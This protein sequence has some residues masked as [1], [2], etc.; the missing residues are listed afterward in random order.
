MRGRAHKPRQRGA[1][2]AATA[3]LLAALVL[4]FFPA[5]SMAQSSDGLLNLDV[6]AQAGQVLLHFT[7]LP[8]DFLY[9]PALRSG[10]GSND[11]ELDRGQFDRTRWVRF[12]RVGNRVLLIEPNLA[13]RAGGGGSAEHRAVEESFTQSVLAGF[14]I[15]EGDADITVDIAPFL[16]SDVRRIGS[17]IAELD[18]GSFELD[19]DRS[20]IEFDG[21]RNFPSNSLLPVTMTFSGSEPGAFIRSVTPTA[22]SLTVRVVHQFIRLPD[23]GYAPRRFHPRS[24]Y[25]PLAY[26]DYGAPLNEDVER[27][28]IYRHRLQP[29]QILHYYV[30][31]GAP[32]PV[33]SALLEGASWWSEAFAAAGFPG[34]FSVDVLPENADPLD[35]RYNVIQWVHRSTRGWS[36]G[37]SVADPRNGEIIKGHVSLGSL[38]VRQDQLIAEALTAPFTSAD[39]RSDAAQEMALARLRQLAAHE[40]GHTLGLDHNFAASFSGDA[41]VMDYPHPELYLGENGDIRL[42]RAYRVGISPWDK[43]AIRYGYTVFP[44]HQE[45]KGLAAILAEAGKAGIAFISDPDARPA[46]SA[47]RGANLW[48]N[49]H[50]ALAR[51]D[52]LLAI[53]RAGL[54][55]FS[56]AVV[57]PD[58]PLSDMERRLV[59]VYLLHRY[60]VQAVAKLLGGLEYDYLMK[61]DDNR[62][63]PVASA[64]QLGALGALTALLE[65]RR[66]A[67]PESL[68]YLIP[69]PPLGYS[70]NREY[71]ADATGQP[72]D[73]LAPARAGTDLVVR[74]LLQPQRL[75]RVRE[76]HA[77]NPDLPGIGQVTDALLGASWES[78][79]PRDPYLA[80]IRE[81]VRWRVLR[82]LM[83][84]SADASASD[85]VR[86]AG[87]AAL[88]HLDDELGRGKYRREATARAARDQIRRFFTRPP[89]ESGTPADPVPPGSPIGG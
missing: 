57:P 60:Q 24:G 63:Q 35:V 88:L 79:A 75:A 31:G 34:T 49:G 21:V 19:P 33:R 6:D 8:S 30:D 27:R 82:G 67:L 68:R 7:D 73:Q 20:A 17:H 10:V 84:L 74:E 89:A 54:E 72:F 50:N 5:S 80:A 1:P 38:R 14:P 47:R 40:V 55:H 78:P 83:T 28:L 3:V 51:L 36:Y 64:A 32:E 41:S 76:Q 62:L 44:A 45:A 85:P 66:L 9:A 86:A 70:R 2:A 18:Q 12:E 59:P 39:A 46:G 71:F 37:A 16:L 22:D 52:E 43:L 42:D 25:F 4:I 29:G 61:G 13:F 15:R 65:P 87:T 26:R 23:D 58:R 81:E 53:R 77:L 48:D 56:A 69:P 11:L